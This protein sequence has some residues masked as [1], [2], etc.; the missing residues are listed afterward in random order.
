MA[1]IATSSND[2]ALDI[3]QDAMLKL[4][5]KYA[6]RPPQEWGPLFHRIMQSTIKDW[7]R[8]QAVRRK[9]QSFLSIGGVKQEENEAQ[10]LFENVADRCMHEPD[11]QMH[12][13]QSMQDLQ[14]ALSGLPRRQQQVFILRVWEGLS[15]KQAA[16]A[17][18]CSE[19]SVKTHY[20]R[21]V[22][23]LQKALK[24]YI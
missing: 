2:E 3:V 24:E 11:Q 1:S 10:N 21:A 16:N 12:L 14:Q 17:M 20:F 6:H 19:G 18:G 15:V 5:Q 7:Y 13:G 4:A 8:R 23:A 9:W 22:Q